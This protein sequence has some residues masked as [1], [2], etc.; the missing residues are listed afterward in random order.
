MSRRERLF[1]AAQKTKAN[2]SVWRQGALCTFAIPNLDG[3]N[4]Q[5]TCCRLR[6][7]KTHAND[8]KLRQSERAPHIAEWP[9]IYL[10]L[11]CLCGRHNWIGLKTAATPFFFSPKLS[12]IKCAEP[13]F[14]H[15]M[16]NEALAAVS[17]FKL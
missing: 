9:F 4:T 11:C 8:T 3:G 15:E 14:I 2:T 10:I 17:H 7:I 5:A 13:C 12:P 16:H 1:T 6:L